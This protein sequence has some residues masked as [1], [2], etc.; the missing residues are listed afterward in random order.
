LR[1]EPSRFLGRSAE[2]ETLDEALLDRQLVTIVGPAGIG[3]TR[4]ALRYATTR[5]PR[6]RSVWFC[7]L[8]DARDVEDMARTVL[9][10]LSRDAVAS[11]EAST[12]A[13]RALA[14]RP[15]A[16][17]V[18]DN[19]EHLLPGAVTV[20]RRWMAASPDL[21]FVVTS[22]VALALE[23][24]KIFELGAL[25]I[26]PVGA[27]SSDAVDLFVE[28]VRSRLVKYAPRDAELVDIAAIVRR[29]HGVPLAIELAA[30]HVG[31]GESG[32]GVGGRAAP[33]EAHT[34]DV[35]MR[36]SR[37]ASPMPGEDD[38]SVRRALE[39]G[40]SL[41]SPIERDALR[42]CSVF[43]GSFTLQ[44][45]E[46]VVRPSEPAI[47]VRDV[48]VGLAQRNLLQI[49]R[50]Q[51]MRFS[52]CEGIRTLAIDALVDS[53]DA[54]GTMWR[55]AEHCIERAQAITD[56]ACPADAADDWDDLQAAMAFGAATGRPQIVLRTALAIDVL[57]HGSGLSSTQLAYLDEALR[58]GAAG[59][60]NLVAR[61]LGVRAG[62]L[63]GLGRLDE[64]REDARMAL[65]LASEIHDARQKGAMLRMTGEV[66]FQQG[67]L[68]AARELL[69]KALAVEEERGDRAS[70]GA[71]HYRYASLVQSLGDPALAR[72]HYER[73]FALAKEARD[74]AGEAR[75]TMGLAWGH[76][77]RGDHGEAL[78]HYER[79]LVLL[80]RL[81][82][83]RSE[84]IVIGYAGLVHFDAG[85]LAE[86]EDHL[87]RAAFAS[88][89]AG[90]FWV[91][92]IFEGVRGAVLAT[93][94]C[95]EE[96]RGSFDLAE[97]LLAGNPFY[98][99]T[100]AIH[101]G[102]L[103]LAEARAAAVTGDTDA[104]EAWMA[105]ARERVTYARDHALRSDDA[106]MA[107]RILVRSL[108]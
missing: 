107:I 3:K 41:L 57:A 24:E 27:T 101:H 32:A 5:E 11:A 85:D 68:E 90:D 86:A 103:D 81:K 13:S 71:V 70:L 56:G 102:H 16:L 22:R 88:R 17:V 9:R 89:Q 37:R 93:L 23:E 82:M 46:R 40:F 7:D 69:E 49:D 12:A 44:A 42:Q 94:D 14:A 43:R 59:D 20:V 98:A 52:M 50:W 108:A 6:Y 73:S 47:A 80:R 33:L 78:L 45:A 39:R 74:A 38:G 34:H 100:I 15:G 53:S 67:D 31:W 4:L 54:D 25:G 105:S 21:R 76:F 104:V 92:G 84:R 79:A 65:R 60:L 30:A 66:A 91:E 26:P 64:A 97:Q 48:V 1:P 51:P 106:R 55:H 77:D 62:A 75:A 99:G 35:L 29:L 18:L 87:R 95:L 83:A 19:I 61:A 72:T 96:A 58:L 28:R 36:V 63:Y 10:T 2:L 8:S